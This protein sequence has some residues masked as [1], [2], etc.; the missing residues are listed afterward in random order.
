MRV[1]GNLHITVKASGR[2][3]PRLLAELKFFVSRK[4][5]YDLIFGPSNS[6]GLFT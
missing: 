4:N 1:P 5:P 6:A 3:V 2:P